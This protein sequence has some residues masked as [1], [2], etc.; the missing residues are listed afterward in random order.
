METRLYLVAFLCFLLD[1]TS[2]QAAR[3]TAP[4]RTTRPGGT[5]GTETFAPVTEPAT[6]AA[7]PIVA[8]AAPLPSPM[9]SAGL[10]VAVPVG[11]PALP[12]ALAPGLPNILA[13][14][15]VAT[16]PSAPVARRTF[17]PAPP[18]IAGQ[19]EENVN[20]D[21][22]ESSDKAN[23]IN[24]I[25]LCEEVE[26]VL[27][28]GST[29]EECFVGEAVT[30]RYWQP[31]RALRTIKC[32]NAA[33]NGTESSGASRDQ[34]PKVYPGASCVQRYQQFVV[35]AS[36]GPAAS[37]WSCVRLGSGCSCSVRNRKRLRM[38]DWEQRTDLREFMKS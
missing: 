34:C 24:A 35:L 13:N 27:K 3:R 32:K 11:L 19:S 20:E 6:T 7:P 26:E 9:A 2:S 4:R 12:I 28:P 8:G 18:P 15:P 21:V 1:R 37:G 38:T 33:I 31:Y 36:M 17:A 22:G 30:L 23:R 16:T 5:Y 10:P 29:Q 25:S 14:L